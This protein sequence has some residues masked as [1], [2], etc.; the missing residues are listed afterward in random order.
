MNAGRFEFPDT[1]ASCDAGSIQ[2]FTQQAPFVITDFQ[3]GPS[4]NDLFLEW[5][6][7]PGQ[8]CRIGNNN[9]LLGDWGSI[10]EVIGSSG[11]STSYTHLG[12]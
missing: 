9:D 2:L 8:A 5:N 3:R 12:G 11:S 4:A 10:I 6:S 7:A 1:T